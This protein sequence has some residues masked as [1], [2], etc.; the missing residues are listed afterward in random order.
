MGLFLKATGEQKLAI[1]NEYNRAIEEAKARHNGEMQKLTEM[2]K[3]REM[4]AYADLFGAI[5]NISANGN[6]KMFAI[7]KMA[8]LSQAIISGVAA[9]QKAYAEGGWPAGIAMGVQTAANVMAIQKQ[10]Y[11]GGR[12]YGGPVEAGKYYRINETGAPEIYSAGGRDY[13]MATENAKVKP[14]SEVGAGGGGWNG[15]IIVNNAPPGTTAEF[16]GTDVIVQIARDEAA[17]ASAGLYNRM[18]GEVASNQGKFYTAM[19]RNTT[20]R[21]RPES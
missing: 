9:V 17:K 4:G 18:T 11:G 14:A 7:H 3:E 21:G 15:N 13:L 16:N 5:A 6:K 19:T 2:R 12:M 10:Q 8:S 20:I 1:E